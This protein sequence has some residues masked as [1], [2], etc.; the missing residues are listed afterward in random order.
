ME[1]TSPSVARAARKFQRSM[2]TMADESGTTISLRA[3]GGPTVTVAEP[4]GV[5]P[6]EQGEPF[7]MAPEVHDVADELMDRFPTFSHLAEHRLAYLFQTAMP[8]PRGGCATI[9]RAHVVND[10]YRTVTGGLDG[11]VVVNK[12][13]WDTA[14]DRQRQALVYH[15]LCHFDTNPETGALGTVKHDLELFIGEA[16]HFGDWRVAI[17]ELAEQL[18]VWDRNERQD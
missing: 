8:K 4:G 10:L 13:W 15:E 6:P 9:G 7:V 3:G 5:I 2:Q 14:T 16:A 12:P 11:I 17:R 18:S 1:V